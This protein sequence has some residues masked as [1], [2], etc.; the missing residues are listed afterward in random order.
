MNE[1]LIGLNLGTI[2]AVVGASLLFGIAYNWFVSWL[3]SSG[4]GEGYTSFLVVGG[5]LI[6]LA[7]ASFLIGSHNALLVLAVFACT[8]LPM[9]IGDVYR[10]TEA[11]REAR[12][13]LEIALREI[14]HDNTSKEVA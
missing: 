10:Y 12:M 8:G 13:E 4:R 9:V 3:N 1:E 14:A 11:R 7:L 6:T 2:G 5:V